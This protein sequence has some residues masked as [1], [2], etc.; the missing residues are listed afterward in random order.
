[1]AFDIIKILI[2]YCLPINLL[3]QLL[4]Y[5]SPLYDTCAPSRAVS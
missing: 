4:P 5:S 1:M 2:L 3:L